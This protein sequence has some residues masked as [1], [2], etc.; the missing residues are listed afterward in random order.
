MTY[1]VV[2]LFSRCS[3]LHDAHRRFEDAANCFTELTKRYGGVIPVHPITQKYVWAIA[4]I[5]RKGNQRNYSNPERDQAKSLNLDQE[6]L[7]TDIPGITTFYHLA[8]MYHE[9]QK[10]IPVSSFKLED[11][12]EPEKRGRHFWSTDAGL[13]QALAYAQQSAFTLELSL[14]AYLEVLGKFAS[15]NGIDIQKWQKHELVDIFKLLTSDEQLQL[16]KLWQNSEVN[17][18]YTVGSFRQFLTLCNKLYNNWRYITDLKSTD[19]SINIP[20]L[21]SASEFLI[22]ASDREFRK[23]TPVKFNFTAETHTSE[24]GHDGKSFP[25]RIHKSIEG[26]VCSVTIPDGHDPYSMVEVIIDSDLHAEE[27]I[28]LFRKRDVRNYYG[29]EGKN[30]TI[31]GDVEENRPNV[32]VYAEHLDVPQLE[33]KYMCEYVTLKGSIWDIKIAHSAHRGTAKVNLVLWDTTYF[34]QV[35]C[36]F[37][38]NEERG[39]LAGLQ[40]GD[41]ILVT[42]LVTL[43]EGLPM[44]LVAP[45][46]VEVVE[47]DDRF[48]ETTVR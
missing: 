35:E 46:T 44:V 30:V 33:P 32:F 41:T 4:A 6:A 10:L 19:I 48:T 43:L 8:K 45:E 31:I 24:D 11:I 14:K 29:L 34:T 9:A 38:T 13:G 18:N 23:R 39:K 21:R 37:V 28:A 25:K 17:R 3:D 27:V 12:L 40:L 20:M 36:Y 2:S 47:E 42:G 15:S 1:E 5:D 26:R 22:S 7:L 16:E